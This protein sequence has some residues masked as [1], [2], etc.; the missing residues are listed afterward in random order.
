LLRYEGIRALVELV[1]KDVGLKD[2][3]EQMML[4]SS[5]LLLEDRNQYYAVE[6]LSLLT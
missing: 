4:T 5:K 6:V 3:F 2:H 1:K